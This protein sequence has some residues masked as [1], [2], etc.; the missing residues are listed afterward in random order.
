MET[1]EP[2]L[3]TGIEQQKSLSPTLD[4]RPALLTV[5]LRDHRLERRTSG[6]EGSVTDRHRVGQ[7]QVAKDVGQ[8]T[9]RF[10]QSRLNGWPASDTVSTVVSDSSRR[11]TW[12]TLCRRRR[13]GEL[14][15]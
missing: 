7:R 4:V 6:A 11:A 5:E 3:S 14:P 15:V 2:G 8:R 9:G 12:T 10:V 1:L 13:V